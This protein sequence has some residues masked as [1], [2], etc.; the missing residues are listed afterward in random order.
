MDYVSR[1][2]HDKSIAFFMEFLDKCVKDDFRKK[3][4]SSLDREKPITGRFFKHATEVDVQ[5]L[6]QTIVGATL[7]NANAIVLWGPPKNP[8]AFKMSGRAGRLN[9][10][11]VTDADS[12]ARLSIG[13]STR[14]VFFD[15]KRERAY[16]CGDDGSK[17][18]NG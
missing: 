5:D 6:L 15:G 10:V 8:I 18:K 9:D 16:V 1:L 12:M 17:R 11:F 7:R 13:N 4:V 2:Q 14:F 3:L